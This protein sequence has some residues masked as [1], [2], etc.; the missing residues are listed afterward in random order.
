[1]R[2][3]EPVVLGGLVRERTKE[4]NKGVPILQ[5]IPLL[6]ILFRRTETE[7]NKREIIVLITPTI[8]DTD[9]ASQME[10]GNM[11]LQRFDQYRKDHQPSL[12]Y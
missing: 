12:F 8:L 4:V 7:T 10:S 9:R 11:A 2:D 6:G 3:G 1:V 5:D